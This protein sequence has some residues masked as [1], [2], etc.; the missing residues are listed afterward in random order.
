MTTKEEGAVTAERIREE[1]RKE[2]FSSVP[3]KEIYLT[4]SIGLAQY[5]KNE[6]IKS[7][8]NRV[9]HFMYRSKKNGKDRVYFE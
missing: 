5:E 8:V 2:N 6:S 7:F 4:V 3:D 1:L 9:D